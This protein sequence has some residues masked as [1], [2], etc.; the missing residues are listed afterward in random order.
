MKKLLFF[1]SFLYFTSCR[2]ICNG[3]DLPKSVEECTQEEGFFY[4]SECCYQSIVGIYDNGES[5][6][7][8]C[9]DLEKDRNLT[10]YK[11]YFDNYYIINQDNRYYIEE[12]KCRGRSYP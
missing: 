5:K 2:K 11:K 9:I 1:L 6:F 3:I 7:A 12:I 4:D 10:D 8:T